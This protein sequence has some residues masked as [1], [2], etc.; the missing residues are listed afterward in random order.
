M[1]TITTTSAIPSTES[2]EVL[3]ASK[4]APADEGPSEDG[5]ASKEAARYRVALREAEAARD[6]VTAQLDAARRSLVEHLAQRENVRPAALWA[7]GVE[8][9]SLLDEAGNVNPTAVAEA[10]DNAVRTLGLSRTPKP[11]PAQAASSYTRPPSP[12]FA[13]A[14]KN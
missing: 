6:A 2:G 5:K 13:D 14:F 8:L 9:S 4:T 11:D 12:R 7:S 10:C 1:T 3:D